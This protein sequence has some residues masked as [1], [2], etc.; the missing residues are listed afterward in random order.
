MVHEDAK[1]ASLQLGRP[2]L[3]NPSASMSKGTSSCYCWWGDRLSLV[4]DP[5][6]ETELRPERR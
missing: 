5:L 6:I 4:V 2:L 3:R 1:H